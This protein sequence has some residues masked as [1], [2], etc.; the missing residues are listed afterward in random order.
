MHSSQDN[1]FYKILNSPS[2]IRLVDFHQSEIE[3]V[4]KL[5]RQKKIGVTVDWR[6]WPIGKP[7][8]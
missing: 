7:L 1:V 8:P 2:P 3:A 4:Q 5:I 6:V